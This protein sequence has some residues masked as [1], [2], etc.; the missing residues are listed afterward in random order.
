MRYFRNKLGDLARF[1]HKT[2]QLSKAIVIHRKR[3]T[4]G[5]ATR[6]HSQPNNET[7]ALFTKILSKALQ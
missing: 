2:D 3:L 5:H 1:I 4:F 7:I 6:S